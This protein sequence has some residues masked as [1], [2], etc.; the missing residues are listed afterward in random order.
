[1]LACVAQ[2]V[3]QMGDNVI[4]VVV[5]K[6]AES[7][8]VDIGTHL[9]ALLPVLAFEGAT[10]RNR[11]QLQIG[12]IVY[13][14][15]ETGFKDMEVELTCVGADG[16]ANGMGELSPNGLVFPCSLGQARALYDPSCSV[17]Q[18]IGAHVPYELA[19]GH[20]GRVWVNAATAAHAIL[21]RV[22]VLR[23]FA[24]D[25]P[26]DLVKQLVQRLA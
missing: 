2:Y 15:V 1:M 22:A 19:V 20:N 4:G 8:K 13:A 17:L 18:L 14:R 12:T 11:P 10:K 21:V 3:A 23:S 7:Y 26:T 5:D 25:D 9:P 6:H 16:K 24:F